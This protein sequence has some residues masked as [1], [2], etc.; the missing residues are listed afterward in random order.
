MAV[1]GAPWRLE[2][3]LDPLELELEMVVS[4]HLGAGNGTW[5]L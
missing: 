1:P 3:I 5:V 2:R 4:C